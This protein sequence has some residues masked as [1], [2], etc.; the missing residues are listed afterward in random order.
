MCERYQNECKC[1]FTIDDRL[2]NLN[3]IIIATFDNSLFNIDNT[4][5][6]ME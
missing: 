6:G 5:V 3:E 4:L 1:K 2:K